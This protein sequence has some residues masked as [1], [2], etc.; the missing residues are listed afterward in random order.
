MDENNPYSFIA[1]DIIVWN[2]IIGQ[3]GSLS[4]FIDKKDEMRKAS[5]EEIETYK[6]VNV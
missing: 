1:T 3:Y 6:N 5:L 2:G 4:H